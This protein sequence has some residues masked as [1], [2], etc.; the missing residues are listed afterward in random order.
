MSRLANAVEEMLS[1]TGEGFQLSLAERTTESFSLYDRTSI[2]F[3]DDTLTAAGVVVPL[4]VTKVTLSTKGCT[5]EG[6]IQIQDG[7][8]MPRKSLI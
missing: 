2:A 5:T 8:E 4:V 1:I 7:H 3:A 6:R